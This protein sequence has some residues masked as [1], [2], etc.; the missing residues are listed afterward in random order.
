MRQQTTSVLELSCPRFRQEEQ[1]CSDGGAELMNRVIS[2]YGVLAIALFSLTGCSRQEDSAMMAMLPEQIYRAEVTY[3]VYSSATTR[4]LNSD[5]ILSLQE[6]LATLMPEQ[7]TFTA[8]EAP[9][10]VYAGGEAY[11]F[12]INDGEYAFSYLLID[13]AYLFMDNEW[14]LLPDTSAPPLEMDG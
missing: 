3:Y 8:G 9:N 11:A 13:N 14:Y 6:W 12:V 5:E 7:V 1:I 2:F 10:E 4:E